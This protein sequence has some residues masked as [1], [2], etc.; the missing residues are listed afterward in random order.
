MVRLGL[1]LLNTRPGSGNKNQKWIDSLRV[2]CKAGHG[3]NGD[4]RIGGLGNQK[5]CQKVWI[6]W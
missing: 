4:P 3:G 1:S 2:F 5:K 6:F